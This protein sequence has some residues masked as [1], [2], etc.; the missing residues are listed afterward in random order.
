[1]LTKTGSSGVTEHVH[2]A[3]NRLVQLRNAGFV[4]VD[5]AYDPAGNLLGRT[6]SS[7]ASTQYEYD[8][9]GWISR[10]RHFDAVNALIS[11]T[12]YVRDRMGNILN[13]TLSVGSSVNASAMLTAGTT[14]Y[15]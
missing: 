7:G 5:Y 6:M 13:Q 11:D 1:V 10:L 15:A 2:N 12:S 4:Q 3:A 8:K 14:T 9:N